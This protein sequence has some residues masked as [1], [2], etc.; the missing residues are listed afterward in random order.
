MPA[1]SFI[2]RPKA[3]HLDVPQGYLECPVGMSV[4]V[5]EAENGLHVLV[6]HMDVG[7]GQDIETPFSV[8]L[9]LTPFDISAL[10]ASL[11]GA[12]TPQT[13]VPSGREQFRN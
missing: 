1:D 4:E 12:N 6:L 7:V 10:V 2:I 8:G 9:A 13:Y 5:R 3:G 11:V